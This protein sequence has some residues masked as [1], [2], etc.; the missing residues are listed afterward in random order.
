MKM[1]C[2]TVLVWLT[3]VLLC[4]GDA[5]GQGES[6]FPNKRPGGAVLQPYNVDPA[7]VSVSGI[8][9]GGFMAAQLGVAYSSVFSRGFGVFAG[10][11]YGCARSQKFSACMGNS[12]PDISAPQAHMEDWSGSRID[13]VQN[14]AG[15]RIYMW[16]G[17][18]DTTVGPNVAKMLDRELSRWYR[19]ENVSYKVSDGA[20]H[21]FPTDFNAPGNNPCSAAGKPYVSNCGYDGAGEVLKWLYGKL[22]GRSD[23]PPA[24]HI[25]SFDQTS[26]IADG[27]GMDSIGYVYVP[28]D[29]AAGRPCRLHVALHGCEQG[30]GSVGMSFINNSGYNRWAETNRIIILYPQARPD[31]KF[32]RTPGSGYLPNPKGCWDWVG[33]YGEDYDRH[34][35][36]QIEAIVGMVRKITGG[37][38]K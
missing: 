34:G 22:K 2:L 17:A 3:A 9:A 10:G 35:G 13:P 14:L 30:H 36:A 31:W 25:T 8:S 26:F 11:P 16:V 27:R 33:W 15:R 20:D 5:A 38:K 1:L 12:T 21:T 28:A 24:G 18:R 19:P 6:A 7:T 29:C 23:N 37:R 32:H 4:A